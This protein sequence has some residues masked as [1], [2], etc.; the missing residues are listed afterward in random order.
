[1]SKFEGRKVAMFRC[2]RDPMIGPTP[3][4][5]YMVDQ[6]GEAELTEH[7]V[8]IHVSKKGPVTEHLIPYA[9]I[10]SIRL[11]LVPEEI[12]KPLKKSQA[13]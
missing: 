1:M 10:E 5:A 8:F 12:K 3:K 11:E 7:G 6:L 2:Y 4:N 9:N 13:V